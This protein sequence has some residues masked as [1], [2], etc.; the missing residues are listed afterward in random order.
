[1]IVSTFENSAKERTS[2][3]SV[4]KRIW[5]TATGEERS[6][7]V[8]AYRDQARRQR[9]EKCASKGEA[10]ERKRAIEN[11]LQAGTH[12]PTSS[13][14]TLAD[15]AK[16]WITR[17]E[18]ENLEEST[19]VQRRQHVAHVLS[20]FG[21]ETRLAK[22][23]RPQIEAG[24]DRLLKACSVALSRKVLTSLKSLLKDA[25]ARGMVANNPARD[26]E[27][28]TNG[29]HKKRLESGVDLPSPEQRTALLEAADPKA[30][31][32]VALAGLAGLRASEIRG[33]RWSD[34]A[35]GEKASVTVRERADFRG[36]IGSPKS[37]AA[38]R[39]VPLGQTAAQALR[40]WKLAQPNGRTL[41]FGTAHDRPDGHGNLQRRVLT[42]LCAAAKIPNFGWH[43]LR[44]AAVSSW[45]AS[46]IDIKTVQTWAGHSSATL[47][48]DVYGH[49][50]PRHDDHAR[51][52][53][54]ESW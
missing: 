27:I 32:M 45:L 43:G 18:A 20:L 4:R 9:I 49:F 50:L 12:T 2:M 33:L 10:Q 15:A 41:V 40:A 44:H 16:A 34:L 36:K 26:V 54:A 30:K 24:R 35:L 52:E 23:T 11:E 21:A 38:R 53:A 1:M 8:V 39:T 22:L 5:T 14:T 3:A 28:R 48:L 47:T 19:I 42:P 51:I 46:G 25:Q 6:A 7:W 37:A 29:R 17:G 31:A 13:K